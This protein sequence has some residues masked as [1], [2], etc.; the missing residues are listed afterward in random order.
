MF[1][2]AV[3]YISF[4]GTLLSTDFQQALREAAPATPL[5]MDL[6]CSQ[7]DQKDVVVTFENIGDKNIRYSSERTIDD[8]FRLELYD[9]AGNLVTTTKYKRKPLGPGGAIVVSGEIM[10]LKPGEKD[11]FTLHLPDLFV[12]KKRGNYS[13]KVTRKLKANSPPDHEVSCRMIKVSLD[14]STW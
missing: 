5:N 8:D 11:T 9:P 10:L 7:S 2:L 3:I 14:P 1:L 12:L 4:T 13:F 6:S